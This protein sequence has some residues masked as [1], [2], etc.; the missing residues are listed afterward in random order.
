MEAAANLRET[1][2]DMIEWRDYLLLTKEYEP[3]VMA[4]HA[5][6]KRLSK[7]IETLEDN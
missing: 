1:L 3:Y 4:L 2:N 5:F 7:D 6:I